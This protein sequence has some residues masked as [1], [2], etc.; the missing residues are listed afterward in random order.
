MKVVPSLNH[1]YPQTQGTQI[2]KNAISL[3]LIEI[4]QL[5]L[6]YYLKSVETLPLMGGCMV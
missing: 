4:I 6:I 3:K 1:T 5:C 2:T